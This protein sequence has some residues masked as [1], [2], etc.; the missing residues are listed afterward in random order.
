MQRQVILIKVE[1]FGPLEGTR[2]W[3][4]YDDGAFAL[5]I[6]KF[7]PGLIDMNP[8]T[9]R[10]IFSDGKGHWFETDLQYK[11][12]KN[13]NT[14]FERQTNLRTGEV[15]YYGPDG[16]LLVHQPMSGDA[17]LDALHELQN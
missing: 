15:S 8:Y 12:Y 5:R 9:V 4:Y 6:V 16:E 13:L 2:H 14:G 17:M 7:G 1:E 3:R 10:S 11:R